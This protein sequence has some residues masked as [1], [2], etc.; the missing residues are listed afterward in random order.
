MCCMPTGIADDASIQIIKLMKL[1]KI[2]SVVQLGLSILNMFSSISSGLFMLMGALILFLITCSKNWCTSVFYVVLTMM[3]FTQ[4]LMLVGNYLAQNGK[5][6]S[7]EG[8]LLFIIMVKLPFYIV[9]MY[10]SFLAYRELKALFL[11]VVS[12]SNQQVMQS[13]SRSWDEQPARR[14]PP[15]PAP[16]SGT[17]YRLG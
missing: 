17:G 11:E 15:P 6:D 1:L 4:S 3:D 9:T 14:D 12:N 5:I 2:L 16:Y 8:I 13:F 7:G 10:Y